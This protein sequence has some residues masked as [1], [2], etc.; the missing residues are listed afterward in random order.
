[1]KKVLKK[2]YYWQEEFIEDLE[3]NK[4]D[5]KTIDNYF[6]VTNFFISFINVYNKEIKLYD[7]DTKLIKRFFNHREEI[8]KEKY[9]KDQ[10]SEWTIKNY[11]KGLKI[12]FKYIEEEDH[13]SD[14]VFNIKWLKL[15]P[16]MPKKEKPHISKEEVEKFLLQLEKDITNK[17]NEI[18]YT[19]SMAFKLIL[20][21]GLR[22]TEVCM[23]K[24][25][26]FGDSYNIKDEEG[27]NQKFID[28]KIKGKGKTYYSN[29]IPY[30][31]IK[32]EL[33]Y[34]KRIRKEEDIMLKQKRGGNLTR[35]SLYQYFKE[36]SDKARI[37]NTGVHKIRHTFA[38]NLADSGADLL[39]MQDLLRHADASTTRIYVKRNQNRMRK[40]VTKL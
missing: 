27:G 40:A 37:D 30:E 5:K 9:N 16:I 12:F 21:S 22:A 15:T 14:K 29:P 11:I 33:N 4:K 34:F 8:V 36:V 6:R 2:L 20:Y 17:R 23:T 25:E 18:S 26:Y 7:I 35:E 32:K 19:L 1:M 39:E 28:L 38:N 24:L 13:K 10:L 31:K 3:L